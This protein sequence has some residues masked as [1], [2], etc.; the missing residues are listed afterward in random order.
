MSIH[1]TQIK[2]A[3]KAGIILEEI[4][5][6]ENVLARWPK[7][8][9]S[10]E[11]ASAADAL[12]QMDAIQRIY[13]E[14]NDKYTVQTGIEPRMIHVV[15]PEEGISEAMTPTDA[16]KRLRKDK[17]TFSMQSFSDTLGNGHA[18][19]VDGSDAP[20]HGAKSDD[21]PFEDPNPVSLVVKRAEN[22]VALDGGVAYREGTP[23]GDCPFNSET[24]DD[25]EYANFEKWNEEWDA[26]ADEAAENGEEQDGTPTGG[27]VVSA[28]YRQRYAELGHPTHCGDW[29]AETLNGFCTGSAHTDLTVFEA[30][31]GENGVDTS[32]YKRDGIGWQG[33]IRMTGRNLLA[34]RVYTAGGIL[35]LPV[36]LHQDGVTELK[37]PAEWMA[38][39]RY[40]MPKAAQ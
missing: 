19:N 11:F 20:E 40:K 2:K 39:Q 14:F 29:L 32:R 36:T 37:A 22:G 10:M 30:I 6:S 5:G 23:A 7:R 28:R 9:V 33:R 3:E 1:H 31:C 4:E 18:E 8:A 13:S 17:V 35:R 38:A 26:A 25:E 16:I 24:D 27:S 12:T 15:W 21:E 34:K